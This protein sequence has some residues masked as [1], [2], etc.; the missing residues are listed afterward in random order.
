MRSIRREIN[1]FNKA[2]SYSSICLFTSNI[3]GE[4]VLHQ[5]LFCFLKNWQHL[6]REMLQLGFETEIQELINLPLQRSTMKK[7]LGH[8]QSG[9][10]TTPLAL[11]GQ[12]E[13]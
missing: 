10:T 2:W 8:V 3:I 1:L 9:K 6:R 4:N 5:V 13:I 7:Y 12:S 11:W